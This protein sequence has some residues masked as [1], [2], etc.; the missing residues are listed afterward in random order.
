MIA[1]IG[2][3]R[4]WWRMLAGA[5]LCIVPGFTMGRLSG[6]TAANGWYQALVLP[7]WQPPGPVFGIAWALL[8]TLVGAAAGLV[9]AARAPQRGYALA[10]F[11]FQLLLNLGWSPL[12]FVGHAVL[13][14]LA[15]LLGVLA[16]AIA[17]TL[18]FARISRTAAW[19]MLPYLVWLS[20]AAVLNLRVYQLNG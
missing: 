15:L 19:L 10:L 12:F 1:A 4:A 5:V 17:T 13:P 2:W 7:P 18:A 11:G 8:Y 3:R 16:F 6:S 9:A 20:Y 14:A